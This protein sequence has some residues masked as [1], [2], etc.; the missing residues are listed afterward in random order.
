MTTR[1]LSIIMMKI[2]YNTKPFIHSDFDRMCWL[3]KVAGFGNLELHLGHLIEAD[4]TVR[5][6][7]RSIAQNKLEILL[8][9]GGWCDFVSGDISQVEKQINL[10]WMLNVNIIR[11]FFSPLPVNTLGEVEIKNLLFNITNVAANHPEMHILFETHHGIGLDAKKVSA[12]MEEVS[13]KH[14]NVRLVFDPIN[15]VVDGQNPEDAL[16]RL[17]P[18]VDHVHLKGFQ[19]KK[20]CAF[21]EGVDISPVA[22]KLLKSTNSFGLEYEGQGD[23]IF[24]LQKSTIN[25]IKL[26][27]TYDIKVTG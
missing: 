26:C 18:Y 21:G 8:V 12:V 22:V 5:Q 16:A 24:E 27:H 7:L 25:L 20:L 10:A 11:L 6:I 13:K 23:A 15:F 1:T 19:K 14:S 2:S 9:D 17:H 4:L 3:F